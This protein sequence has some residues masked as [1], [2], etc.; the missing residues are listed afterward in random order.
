MALADLNIQK[1]PKI[2]HRFLVF[3]EEVLQE[4]WDACNSC[5]FLTENLVCKKCSCFMK[6]K[7]RV[8]RM[9]CPVGKW[10]K[11]GS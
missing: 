7:T 5:E 2:L 6:L 8:A 4:R 9:K 10:G 1:I 11:H 3:E